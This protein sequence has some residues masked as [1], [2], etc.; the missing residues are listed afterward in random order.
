MNS[1]FKVWIRKDS[2]KGEEKTFLISSL[3]KP[4]SR[5]INIE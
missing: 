1:H 5:T 4:V 2:T 3:I